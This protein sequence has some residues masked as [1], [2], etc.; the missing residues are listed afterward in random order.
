VV[1]GAAALVAT[2]LFA[3]GELLDGPA[4]LFAGGLWLAILAL[5]VARRRRERARD[6]LDAQIAVHLVVGAFAAIETTGGLGSDFYPLL[7]A[8]IAF[9]VAMTPARVGIVAIVTAVLFEGVLWTRHGSLDDTRRL[10]IHASCIVFFALLQAFFTRGE[11]ARLR[12]EGKRMLDTE[13]ENRLAAARDFRLIGTQ[14]TE[15]PEGRRTGVEERLATASV[16]QIRQSLY[17]TLD[18]LKRTMRLHT[19][20][21]LWLDGTGTT[22]KLVEI[23]TDAT[24][25]EPGPW[26][27]AGGAVGGAIKGGR[28][29]NVDAVRPGYRGIPY[30]NG[31]A[32]VA[33]FVAV[34]V[35]ERGHVRGVLCADRLTGEAFSPEEESVLEA[36]TATVLR[37]TETERLFVQM[38]RAKWEQSRLYRASQALGEALGEGQVLDASLRAVREIAEYDFAAVTTVEA[39]GKRHF[40]RRAEGP[41]RERFEGLEL[42][43]ATALAAMAV[44]NRAPLPYRGDYDADQQVVFSPKARLD[45]M[46][47]LLILPLVV[48]DQAIGTLVIAAHRRDAF[49]S[50]VRPILE[51]ISNQ[52]AVSLANA[53]MVRRLE[54]L[55]TTDGLTG[56]TNHRVFQEELET[57][58][59]SALRFGRPLSVVLL[60]IDHFKRVNDGHGHPVGDAVLKMTARLLLRCKR[61]TDLVARYGGEEF[62]IVCEQTDQAGAELLAERVRRELEVESLQTE[63]G[64]LRITCSLGIAT[65]PADAADKTELVARADQAL[66][67]AKRAGRNR[68]TA[69]PSIATRSTPV[70][71]EK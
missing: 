19:C 63:Q 14:L 48:G 21:L 35:C 37:A 41:L 55:A 17:Q 25:V 9:L 67:H 24:G 59:K 16:D 60:D 30:Y 40:V 50:S 26:P 10:A 58:L 39:D 70:P 64:P 61:E 52:M 66:Y 27:A 11:L 34:P 7:Y 71:A 23:A 54:E 33:R 22:L 6:W 28:V 68:V 43:G 57:R 51:V 8:M 3:H 56:L 65:Y 69:W 42:Q 31:D 20:A 47:S 36:A 44:K 15:R 18:L 45:G 4:A 5:L 38:E 13:R 1:I 2:G 62:A 29:V 53:R 32:P 49:G 46:Q 12:L